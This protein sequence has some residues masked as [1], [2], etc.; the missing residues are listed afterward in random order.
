MLQCKYNANDAQFIPLEMKN[1]IKL[2]AMEQGLYT[3]LIML[4][5]K[6]LKCVAANKNKNG[7]KFKFQGQSARLQRWFDIDLD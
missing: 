6:Y 3:Q 2:M 4:R 1:N 5:Q 7:A